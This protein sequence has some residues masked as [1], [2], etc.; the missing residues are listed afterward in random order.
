MIQARALRTPNSDQWNKQLTIIRRRALQGSTAS[1]D[2]KGQS[3]VGVDVLGLS[4]RA[5]AHHSRIDSILIQFSRV[6]LLVTHQLPPVVD[7]PINLLPAQ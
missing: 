2:D 4:V 3:P 6:D 1:F 7:P 5:L